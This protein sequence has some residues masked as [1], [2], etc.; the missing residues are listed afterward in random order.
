[1]TTAHRPTFHPALAS[2]HQGGY[3]FHLPTTS[4]SKFDVPSK[5]LKRRR[6]AE[7][8]EANKRDLKAELRQRE[9]EHLEKQ[10]RERRRKGRLSEREQEKLRAI[11]E[12]KRSLQAESETEESEAAQ[13]SEESEAVAVSEEADLEQFDDSDVSIVSSDSDDSSDSD[14]DDEDAQLRKMLEQLKAEKIAERAAAE[15]AAA[16][17]AERERD[18]AAAMSNPLLRS[19]ESRTFSSSRAWTESSVFRNQ[20][21]GKADRVEK[22]FVNDTTR[23]DAHRKFMD[24]YIK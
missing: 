9:L 11:E 10:L 5:P 16:E 20:A 23:N 8:D 2:E 21:V 4:R 17:K 18:E 3:R 12:E 19:Q 24:R 15:R 7:G 13:Q 6:H 14:S 22:R 1:M